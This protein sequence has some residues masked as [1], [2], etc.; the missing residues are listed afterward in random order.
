MGAQQ[1]SSAEE[2]AYALQALVKWHEYGGKLPHGR[3]EQAYYWLEKKYNQPYEPLWI[4]KS[5]YCPE[6]V[7]KSTILSALGLVREVGN[8]T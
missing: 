1:S 4:G 8:V 3:V 6:L 2:T 7:V 5:L